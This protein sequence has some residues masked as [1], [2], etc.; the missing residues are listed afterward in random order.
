MVGGAHPARI[1]TAPSKSGPISLILASFCARGP[2][3]TPSDSPSRRSGQLREQVGGG[4]DAAVEVG[5]GELLVGAV[6][7][8]VVL[9]PAEQQGVDAEL[10]LEQADDRDGAPLAD[11]DRPRAETGL[12]R[13]G[14]RADPSA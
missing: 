3:E 6:Q 12:D 9:A 7:V 2:F 4:L 13:P 5:Q 8:V 11:E 1:F 10:G 14:R